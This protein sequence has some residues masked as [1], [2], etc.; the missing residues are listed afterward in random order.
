ME[1][2]T[3]SALL[4]LLPADTWSADTFAVKYTG[5][6]YL[7]KEDEAKLRLLGELVPDEG[8]P[9][10]LMQEYPSGFNYWHA[11]A[12]IALA[13]YPYNGCHVYAHKEQ[14]YLVY[15]E[16]AGHYPEKRCRLVQQQLL[17]TTKPGATT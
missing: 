11:R 6:A 2:I 9:Q 17:I 5:W 4:H 1:K 16:H 14:L 12:P 3:W 15:T 8:M 7:D 10:Y 13:Y